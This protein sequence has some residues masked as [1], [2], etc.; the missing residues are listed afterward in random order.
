MLHNACGIVSS[1]T[2]GYLPCRCEERLAAQERA[3]AAAEAAAAVA[4]SKVETAA[5]ALKMKEQ[6]LAEWRQLAQA[7]KETAS[8]QLQV[9]QVRS[10]KQISFATYSNSSMKLQLLCMHTVTQHT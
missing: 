4:A 7:S 2:A 8:Q 1:A 6:Q 3:A 9:S 5:D 10:G